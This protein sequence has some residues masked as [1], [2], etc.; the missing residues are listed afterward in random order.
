[1]FTSRAEYR[2]LLRED[3]ADLRLTEKARELGLIDDVRW[4][5]FNEKIDNMEKERQRLK[6]T[7]MNPKSAGV[8]ELNALLK[9]P[10]AREAS[11][12]DLLR[13]PEITYAQLTQL[14]AF[15]PTLEDQQ[16]AEQVEIQVKYEGYIK[17]QQDE[18]EKSLRH[19][20]TKLPADLDYK[21]VSGLSNEVVLKLSEAK[22]ESIGIASRISGI[23]PAAISILLVHL[24]KQGLLKKGEEA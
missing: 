15:Q 14:A 22:P 13:R 23:T 12:E 19:E 10:M 2:L 3:N 7:W 21:Q 4:A 20:N 17:R 8:D 24:K 9:A 16:A 1:M 6:E 5:R 11:G 18:I